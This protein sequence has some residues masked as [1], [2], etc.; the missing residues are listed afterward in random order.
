MSDRSEAADDGV[1]LQKVLASAGVASR[2]KAEELIRD[3]RVKVDGIVVREMGTRIDPENAVVHVDGNRITTRTDLVYLALNKERGVLSTMSDEL[4]RPHIGQMLEDRSERLFH[5]GRLDMESEGLLLLTNDGDLAHRLTHPSYGVAK[6][7]VA[8]VPGPIPKD[9][10]RRLKA[11]VELE[12]GPAKVDSFDVMDLHHNRAVV[13]VVIHEGRK[14]IVRRLLE[15]VDR[16]VSRLV[17]TQIGPVQLGH[18]RPGT[19]RKLNP[20]EVSQLY[21]AVGL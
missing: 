14:H 5:V 1:R 9:L 4:G 19:L 17:R 8:E 10:G 15:A 7:Y 6:T 12:D 2:R 11:G 21:K 20:V 18:Q 16:P 3:G 13:E